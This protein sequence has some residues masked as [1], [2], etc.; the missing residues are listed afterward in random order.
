MSVD[1]LKSLLFIPVKRGVISTYWLLKLLSTLRIPPDKFNEPLDQVAFEIAC[2]TYE[3]YYNR[4]LG[5][6]IAV[7]DVKVSEVGRIIPGDGAT[8]HDAEVE[9]LAFNPQQNEVVEGEVKDT[10]PFGLFVNLGPVEGFVHI[11][12]IIDDYVVYDHVRGSFMAKTKGRM[13][14]KGDIIRARVVS[15]GFSQ[16]KRAIRIGMTMRQPGLGKIEWIKEPLKA[17]EGKEGGEK[18]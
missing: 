12:Q 4:E 7:I 2:Q 6:I 13:V 10:A 16:D 8:Y 11:S 3:G 18:K 9:L 14:E 5:L 17:K 1:G 15:I